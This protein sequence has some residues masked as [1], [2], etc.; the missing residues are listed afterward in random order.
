MEL[1]NSYLM[2]DLRGALAT[3]LFCPTESQMIAF[4]V[5]PEEFGQPFEAFRSKA[6]DAIENTN[7][8]LQLW[9]EKDRKANRFAEEYIRISRR[10]EKMVTTLGRG[11][12]TLH[13]QG[14]D[15][16]KAP[17]S[18]EDLLDIASFHFNKS[19]N[20]AKAA[21]ETNPVI[22]ERLMLNQLR[23]M[24]MLLRLERTRDRLNEKVIPEKMVPV[25]SE[26]SE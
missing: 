25:V 12:I 10:I 17:V 2:D 3:G 1:R 18:I 24:N 7:A 13:M 15:L 6:S 26:K 14:E 16:S 8:I 11:L 9:L 4:R 19:C 21:A 22:F 5:L 23:W 20:G